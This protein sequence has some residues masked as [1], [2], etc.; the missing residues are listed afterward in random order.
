MNCT[1]CGM[2]GTCYGCFF[3]TPD[4][5][6]EQAPERVSVTVIDIDES[7]GRYVFAIG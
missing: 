4:T 3:D 5:D 6:I 7:A 2:I 1:V